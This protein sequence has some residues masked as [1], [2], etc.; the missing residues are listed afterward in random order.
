MFGSYDGAYGTYGTAFGTCD[1]ACDRKNGVRSI[2]R[3]GI[4][5]FKWLFKGYLQRFN[6]EFYC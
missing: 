1:N 5:V 6:G 3:Q 4:R 2:V